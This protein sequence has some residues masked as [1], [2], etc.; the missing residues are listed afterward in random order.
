M[1]ANLA[2]VRKVVGQAMTPV[3]AAGAQTVNPIAA[4]LMPHACAGRP[5]TGVR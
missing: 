4:A 5:E 2:R 1:R 3:F